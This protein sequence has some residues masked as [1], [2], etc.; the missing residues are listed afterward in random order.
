MPVLRTQVL[1]L[2]DRT[3][4]PLPIPRH[5][6]VIPHNSAQLAVKLHHCL[7]ALDAEQLG[8]PGLGAGLGF[9]KGVV[10][11]RDRGQRLPRHVVA[12]GVGNHKV[13]IRQPL[14]QRAGPQ[15]VG[16]VVGKICLAQH[17][18]ARNRTHQMVVDP[19]APHGVVHGGIDPH[20]HLVGVFARDPLVH[21]EQ[22]A[23]AG[24][25]GG[26]AL[27]GDRIAKI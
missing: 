15:T 7:V 14:H 25:D 12:Q 11:G 9:P 17:K 13:A 26:L 5:A 8:N 2:G 3:L 16:P 4:Q 1:D 18:Q 19:Q 23:V 6:H 21:V 20:R 10:V 27:G 24:G 22:V